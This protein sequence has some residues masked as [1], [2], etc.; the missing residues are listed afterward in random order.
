MRS[1][2]RRRPQ[3]APAA[4]AVAFVLV[5]MGVIA[6][7]SDGNRPAP[8]AVSPRSTPTTAPPSDCGALVVDGQPLGTRTTADLTGLAGRPVTA[9][10][11]AVEAVPAD[12]GF[13]V[14][15]GQ[16]R[17]W[18]R[19]VGTGESPVAVTA[20]RTVSFTGTIAAHRADFP[21]SQGVTPEQGASELGDSPVH[22]E[23]ARDDLVLE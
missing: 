23:V 16:R 15:C 12:E 8:T 18:I 17:L 2:I 13:W 20:G 9:R 22:I 21:A 14:R 5:I 7:R 3:Q 1:R 4:G 11:V 6:F 10:S 19:L